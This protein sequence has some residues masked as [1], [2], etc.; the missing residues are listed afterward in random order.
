MRPFAKNRHNFCDTA[1]SYIDGVKGRGVTAESDI[2]KGTIV[3]LF[4]GDEVYRLPE[5]GLYPRDAWERRDREDEHMID[6][7]VETLPL[8][9]YAITVGCL[10][11]DANERETGYYYRVLD[12]MAQD[13]TQNRQ[14]DSLWEQLREMDAFFSE[15]P[16]A[17]PYSHWKCVTCE[18]SCSTRDWLWE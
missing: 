11:I 8:S 6:A 15:E 17:L 14:L 12:P 2:P 3:C 1:L 13:A 10:A 4:P 7:A 16:V 9:D 18:R 5:R